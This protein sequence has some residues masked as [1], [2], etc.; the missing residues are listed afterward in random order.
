M[1]NIKVPWYCHLIVYYSTAMVLSC[2]VSEASKVHRIDPRAGPG[3]A[4]NLKPSRLPVSYIPRRRAPRLTRC[5][6]AGPSRYQKHQPWS[7]SLYT[8][9]YRYNNEYGHLMVPPP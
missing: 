7:Q 1:V 5:P 9:Q 8:L 2:R 3:D 6:P 4:E